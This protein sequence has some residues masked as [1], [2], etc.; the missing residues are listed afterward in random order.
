MKPVLVDLRLIVSATR[1]EIG[2]LEKA[3]S[4]MRAPLQELAAEILAR[5]VEHAAAATL[6]AIYE[7][8]RTGGAR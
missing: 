2:S 6:L 3:Q 1:D 7:R 5:E 8:G 4:L